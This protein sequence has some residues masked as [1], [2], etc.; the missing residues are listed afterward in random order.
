MIN[1]I[2]FQ[3]AKRGGPMSEHIEKK[4][5]KKN[6]S[7]EKGLAIIEY[8]SKYQEPIRL[9]DL[10]AGLEMSASTTLRFLITLMENDYVE[11]DATSRYYLTYKVCRIASRVSESNSLTMI[12]RE[13]MK[14]LSEKSKE[15][16]C[17]AVEKEDTIVYIEVVHGPDKLMK[18]LQRIGNIAPMNCTA[19]GKLLLL[20]K[21]DEELDAYFA[22]NQFEVYTG[23]TMVTKDEL[24]PVLEKARLEDIAFDNEECELGV[25]CV[26]LPIRDYTGKIIA[27]MS[28]TGTV[29][30]LSEEFMQEIMPDFRNSIEEISRILG[31]EK[32]Q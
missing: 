2:E 25:R 3:N 17:L 18:T 6:Q 29:Y 12:A 26:A 22:R 16:V 23:N 10:A 7:L 32:L 31:Y 15:S 9:Q 24:M 1:V 19:I 20:N 8:M 27:A 13:Y 30:N 14:R 11:Q 28:I 5:T 4:M 21:T